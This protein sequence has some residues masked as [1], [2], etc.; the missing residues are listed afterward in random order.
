MQVTFQIIITIWTT[1]YYIWDGALI[2]PKLCFNSH[3]PSSNFIQVRFHMPALTEK[4]KNHKPL[5]SL[6]NTDKQLVLRSLTEHAKAVLKHLCAVSDSKSAHSAPGSSSRSSTLTTGG[7]LRT[8]S[9][10]LWRGQKAQMCGKDWKE[11]LPS[12]MPLK[13]KKKGWS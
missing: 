8:I 10:Q 5:Q 1:G 6:W 4:K 3:S 13:K 2:T 12:H 11:L 7:F 9:A